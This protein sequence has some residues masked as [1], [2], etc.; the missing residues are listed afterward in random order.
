M[1]TPAVTHLKKKEKK[2]LGKW[3]QALGLNRD[4]KNQLVSLKHLD[5][6]SV[7]FDF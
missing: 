3:G 2:E 6:G 5:S 1:K 7:L 4:K